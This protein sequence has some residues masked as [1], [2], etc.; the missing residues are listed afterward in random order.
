MKP[1]FVLTAPI[2]TVS[3]A[4]QRNAWGTRKRASSQRQTLGMILR[5]HTFKPG[6]LATPLALRFV[7]IAPRRLDSDNL[8]RAM[9]ALRDELCR[10]LGYDDG[11]ERLTFTYDQERGRPKVYAVRLEVYERARAVVEIVPE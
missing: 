1:S 3:E 8:A 11:D 4:N 5:T 9:K 2:R 7:R 10:W 6:S